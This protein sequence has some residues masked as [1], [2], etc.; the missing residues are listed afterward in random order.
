MWGQCVGRQPA[1]IG[2]PCHAGVLQQ[3]LLQDTAQSPSVLACP[4]PSQV[5]SLKRELAQLKNS[6][7]NADVLRR[8][9]RAVECRGALRAAGERCRGATPVLRPG[10]G[11]TTC[12]VTCT[13]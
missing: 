2:A 12:T 13:A 9:V 4:S 6:V 3:G 5:A 11:C 10:H 7:A 1:A 8:E